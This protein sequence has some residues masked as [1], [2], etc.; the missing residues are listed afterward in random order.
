[1]NSPILLGDYGPPFSCNILVGVP[2]KVPTSSLTQYHC[3]KFIDRK[4]PLS[5]VP[6][7]SLIL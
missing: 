3:F 1:M 6:H 2:L 5:T 4:L 7:I